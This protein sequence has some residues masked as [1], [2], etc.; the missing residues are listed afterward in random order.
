MRALLAFNSRTGFFLEVIKVLRIGIDSDGS[1]YG[2][3]KA[4][5][6]LIISTF[7]SG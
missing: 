6:S 3:G 7:S 5:I 4:P 1:K 2:F